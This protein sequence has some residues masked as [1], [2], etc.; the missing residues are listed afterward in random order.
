MDRNW[1]YLMFAVAAILLGYLLTKSGFWAW[2]YLATSDFAGD[3]VGKPKE[4]VIDLLGFGLAGLAAAVALRNERLVELAGEVTSE[5]KKVTW[6]TREETFAAT[7]VVIVTVIV[8]S[9]FL[10]VFDLLWSW[11]A[12]AI[13]G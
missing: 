1:T 4:L 10:G 3:Y 13:Y 6:P 7:I 12:R 9:I 11:V 8:A 5:L 2:D